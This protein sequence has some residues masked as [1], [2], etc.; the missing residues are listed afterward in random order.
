[1]CL[2]QLSLGRQ[3]APCLVQGLHWAPRVQVKAWRCWGQLCSLGPGRLWPQGQNKGQSDSA[4]I[5]VPAC[6]FGS[7]G[8]CPASHMLTSLLLRNLT[9]TTGN[10]EISSP[11]SLPHDGYSLGFWWKEGRGKK[12]PFPPFFSQYPSN[13]ID[14]SSEGAPTP[15][16]SNHDCPKPA[17]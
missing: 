8:L 2:T 6:D 1:M 9:S 3:T 7:C 14:D 17:L 4:C 13:H 11:M 5:G 15:Y 16:P 10:L 12:H